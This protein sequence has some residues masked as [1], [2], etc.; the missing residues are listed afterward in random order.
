MSSLLSILVKWFDDEWVWV[1]FFLLLIFVIRFPISNVSVI[2][3]DESVYFTIAQDIADGGVPYKT[4]WDNKGPFLYFIFVPIILLF[5]ESISALRIFTTFYLLLSMVF[6]YLLGRKFFHGFVCVIPPL[7]YGLFFV[8]ADFQ[9]FSSNGELFMMLPVILALLCFMN[10][11]DK[12]DV[13]MLFLSGIFSAAAFFTKATAIFSVMVVPLFI[14]YRN[15]K[16]GSPNLKSFFKETAYYSSGFLAVVLAL[17]L[18]FGIHGA[19]YD[20]YYTYFIYNERYMHVIPF[21][22]GL[23]MMFDFVREVTLIKHEIITLAAIASAVYLLIKLIRKRLG[24]QEKNTLYFLL[25]LS[26]LSS[27]GVLWGRHMWHHYY[28]QMGLSYSLLIA[29]AISKLE[30]N[31]SYLKVLIIIFFTVIMLESPIRR[32]ISDIKEEDEYTFDRLATHEVAGYIRNKTTIDEHIL[33]LGGQPDIYFL[34]DRR[35]PIKF[36]WWNDQILVVIKTVLDIEGTLPRMLNNNKPKYI[37]F[38]D[39]TIDEQKLHVSFFDAYI[40]DN[41]SFEKR[42]GNY[43]LYRLNE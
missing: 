20:F 25:I 21:K 42:I 32:A 2:D 11:E 37:I 14:I 30:L 38:Y 27:V 12:G 34:S 31:K 7:I 39:G 4:T 41:Y 17:T 24:Q 29:F 33:V 6:V 15:L 19:L 13:L 9:G 36:F 22:Y 43:K 16:P 3:W 10:Y 5:D 1:S 23:L 40:A 26:V 28:L 35:S 8:I 18:Y